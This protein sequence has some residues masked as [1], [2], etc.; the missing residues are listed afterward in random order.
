[1]TDD[2]PTAEPDDATRIDLRV[3]RQI[4][5]WL[6]ELGCTEDELRDLVAV[7]GVRLKDIRE[8]LEWRRRQQDVCLQGRLEGAR[9]ATAHRRPSAEAQAPKG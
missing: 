8:L 9:A 7:V 2:G 1:M 4:S 3:P 5:Y 6:A